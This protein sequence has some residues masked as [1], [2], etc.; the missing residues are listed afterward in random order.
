[1]QNSFICFIEDVAMEKQNKQITYVNNESQVISVE[2]EKPNEVNATS[3]ID[4][5]D[6]WTIIKQQKWLIVFVTLLVIS[7]TA[8]YTF[9]V[10]EPSYQSSAIIL[11][12]NK[13]GKIEGITGLA[14]K[15]ETEE[16]IF[17]RTQYEM[18]RNKILASRV[19]D[20]LELRGILT[21]KAKKEQTSVEDSFLK[22][23][24]MVPIERTNLVK[25]NYEANSPDLAA[26]AVNTIIA[27][28]TKLQWEDLSS[29]NDSSIAY[30]KGEVSRARN[31]LTSVETKMVK[32]ANKNGILS[33]DTNKVA[34]LSRLTELYRALGLA[35]TTRIQTESA[36]QEAQKNK[37]A[38]EILANPLINSLKT[39]LATV[40]TSYQ[41]KLQMFKPDYP[42]MLMLSGQINDIKRQIKAEIGTSQRSL[43]SRYIAAKNSEEKVAKDLKSLEKD[44]MRLQN[45]S[46]EYNALQREVS[47]KRKL[48]EEL[49]TKFQE[50]KI[51]AKIDANYIKV[52][53]P[54][55]PPQKQYR[56]KP[57]LNL[58]VGSVIGLFLGIAIGFLRN[59][60]SKK[61]TSTRMLQK[62]MGFRILGH[63]PEISGLEDQ[64]EENSVAKSPN[65]AIAQAYRIL[66]TT[67]NNLGHAG[68]KP[69][70]V[71][72][73]TSANPAEGKS[74]VAMNLA[75]A[76]A[77]S[78]NRVL[79]VDADLRRP[80]LHNK[81]GI[82]NSYGFSDYLSGNVEY[83]KIIQ[84]LE[85]QKGLYLMTAGHLSRDP[86]K[87]LSNKK[88][89]E[90]LE[91]ASQYFDHIIIDT[92]PVIGFADT[93]IL[94]P[95]V[96]GIV[97]VVDESNME[98]NKIEDSLNQMMRIN[99]NI[100]GFIVTKAKIDI[101]SNDY[102]KNYYAKNRGKKSKFSSIFGK[103]DKA[104]KS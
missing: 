88:I 39:R 10:V 28:A 50:I 95:T 6:I 14:E 91:H 16:N 23:L 79:L 53:D 12:K 99:T 31:N 82:K 29:S 1:M 22:D 47:S 96:D 58:V 35:A 73:V 45:K 9:I 34:P 93:F 81:A 27:M 5:L 84:A 44:L 48:Y 13:I 62:S 49:V 63:I 104:S 51:S 56:P 38:P 21:E 52:I 76:Q 77:M 68:S 100:L 80:S 37:G 18:I 101:V 61:L 97:F 60:S 42:E 89:R 67:L 3:F 19:V 25:I 66:S 7:I 43:R 36:Y 90:F 85:D 92:P 46:V 15:G 54:A 69:P 32:Y 4:L 75:H 86:A 40:E 30:L 83:T 17:V 72:M 57:A 102:Y 41:E 11:I 64:K 20:E 98:K 33:M 59:S 55:I 78:G 74:T 87:L 8:A 65:S 71:I 26:T 70:K 103:K 2:P 24:S 94:A